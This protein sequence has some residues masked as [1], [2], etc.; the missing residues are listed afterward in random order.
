M[1]LYEALQQ[2]IGEYGITVIR[3]RRLVGL[4]SG[5][6]VLGSAVIRKVMEAFAA[7]GCGKTFG[8]LQPGESGSDIMVHAESIKELLIRDHGFSRSDT[9]MQ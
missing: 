5:L 2:V 7:D 4:L 8:S 6:G 1:K 9:T 3:G